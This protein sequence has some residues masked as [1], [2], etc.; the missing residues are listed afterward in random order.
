MI[1]RYATLGVYSNGEQMRHV[2]VAFVLRYCHEE[3]TGELSAASFFVV[4][5]M[6]MKM[7]MNLEELRS[8]F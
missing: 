4:L 7:N 6:N 8:N 2:Y 1:N 5:N 3:V